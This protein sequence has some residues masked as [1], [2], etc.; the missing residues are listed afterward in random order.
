MF[1]NEADVWVGR[2]YGPYQIT[3]L[4]GRGTVAHVYRA[5][6]RGR[7]EVALKVLT[8]F[9]EA[10]AEVRA[11][12]EQEYELMARL[13]HPNVLETYQAG[14][15]AHTHYMEIELIEGETV[16]DK[17]QRLVRLPVEESIRIVQQMCSALDHVHA[18][19]I[20]HRDV[21]PSNI[22]LAH[23]DGSSAERAVLFD[24]GLSHDLDGPPSPEGRV[25]GSPLFLAPE[26]AVA[27]PVDGRTDLYALG[28]SLYRL[29]VGAAPFYGDRND[30]LHAHVKLDP[31][32]PRNSGVHPDLA[33]IILQ[34]MAKDP[35]ERFQSGADLAAALATIDVEQAEP[36]RKK[37]L[38]KRLGTKH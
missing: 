17:V 13:D 14:V 16:W 9:A 11:L 23:D 36:A 24:F 20:V 8:P 33:D 22:M 27:G 12:F 7:G 19:H 3:E 25:F 4:L 2:Q 37:G 35:D 15:I 18:H 34:A 10:R 21:K 31:P 6:T 1:G 38:L 32:D 26:Q 28:T 30:L 29:V 5:E